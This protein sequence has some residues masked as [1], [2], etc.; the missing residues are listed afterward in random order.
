MAEEKKGTRKIEVSDDTANRIATSLDNTIAGITDAIT[1]EKDLNKK[2]Q[3]R[4]LLASY[5]E[6]QKL[7]L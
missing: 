7:F 6:D 5:Q 2:A 4:E 3:F 1:R